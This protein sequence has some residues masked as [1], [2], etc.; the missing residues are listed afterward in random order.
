MRFRYE[1]MFRLK[2]LSEAFGQDLPP[3]MDKRWAA[4]V[5]WWDEYHRKRLP[6]AGGI[7]QF[8][9]DWA[10]DLKKSMGKDRTAF[11]TWA[12]EEMKKMPE[13]RLQI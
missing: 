11:V 7:G 2:Y 5:M 9:V 8:V 12:K 4:F 3:R 13:V 6:V 1:I 10:F